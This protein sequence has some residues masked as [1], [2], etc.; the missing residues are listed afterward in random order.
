MISSVSTHLSICCFLGLCLFLLAV[1]VIQQ[2]AQVPELQS[3]VVGCADELPP[4]GNQ[5]NAEN[6][7]LPCL[8]A[9]SGWK[10]S[11]SCRLL[12]RSIKLL[13]KQCQPI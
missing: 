9:Y 8:P 7:K 12:Q 2:E 6:D 11:S 3:V 4:A 1:L 5:N 10:A 13:Y